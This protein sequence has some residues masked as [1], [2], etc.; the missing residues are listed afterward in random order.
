[1][2]SNWYGVNQVIGR[3]M[4]RLPVLKLIRT[5]F[6]VFFHVAQGRAGSR[7]PGDAATA[8]KV[9]VVPARVRRPTTRRTRPELGDAAGRNLVMELGSGHP[10]S[11]IRSATATRRSARPSTPSSPRRESGSQGAAA[12]TTG[13][14]QCRTMGS[15]SPLRMP[16][17]P[18]HLWPTAP[19][20]RPRRTC[21][22]RRRPPATPEPGSAPAHRRGAT[23]AGHRPQ[24][25]AGPAKENPQRAD[26]RVFAGSVAESELS[27]GTGTPVHRVVAC[28]ITHRS[29]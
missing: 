13:Q 11:D 20:G 3:P 21:H 23:R 26:Q 19:G 29:R 8:A 1:M 25:G 4:G 17:P 5:D 12:G 16:R 15:H 22:P 24:R 10:S 27:S 28:W 14:R 9:I 6:D 2:R 7:Q 18:V